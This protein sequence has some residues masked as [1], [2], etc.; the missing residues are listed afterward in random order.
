VLRCKPRSTVAFVNDDLVALQGTW[1]QTAL[2]V[3]GV[4]DPPDSYGTGL[5]TTFEG[6][7]WTVHAPDGTVVLAGAFTLDASTKT[8]D[9]IDSMGED[10]GKTLPAIYELDGDNFRF[11][12]GNEGEPRPTMFRTVAGQ[13]MRAFRRVA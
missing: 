1:E 8:I 10:A 3:D 11:V 4:I 9:W 12:A 5:R 7:Q 2:E 6:T 13:T